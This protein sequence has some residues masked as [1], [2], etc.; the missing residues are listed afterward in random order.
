MPNISLTNYT[1]QMRDVERARQY[2]QM[3]QEQATA[4]IEQQTVNGNP[5][6][7]GW[8]SVLAKGLQGYLGGRAARKADER[9]AATKAAMLKEAVDY[10]N[11]NNLNV[12]QG[13]EGLKRIGNVQMDNPGIVD[14]LKGM[15]PQGAPQPMPQAPP[16]PMPQPPPQ[17]MPQPSP[18]PPQPISTDPTRAQGYQAATRS[19][20]GKLTP[21]PEQTVNPNAAFSGFE[22]ADKQNFAIPKELQDRT[23]SS[24][25]KQRMLLAAALSD[26]PY[27]QKIAPSMYEEE[28]AAGKAE[29]AFKLM[30]DLTDLGID[31]KMMNVF[32]ATGDTAGAANYLE[33]LGVN[34]ENQKAALEAYKIKAADTAE[35]RQL[36]RESR[37]SMAQQA[38]ADRRA[39]AAQA[40]ADRLFSANL[41]AQDRRF[42]IQNRESELTPLQQTQ[43]MSIAKTDAAVEGALSAV[44]STPKAFSVQRGAAAKGGALTESLAA[45]ADTPEERAARAQVFNVMS[46]VIKERAGT[47]Q[48]KAELQTLNSFLP[49]AYDSGKVIEDKLTGF[50]KYLQGQEGVVMSVGRHSVVSKPTNNDPMGLR[51]PQ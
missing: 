22:Y 39:M 29:K 14:R 41:A 4:P 42:A 45:R 11:P 7:I 34:K 23:R 48:S 5:V 13:G 24:E 35:Q 31:S 38:S 27:L 10:M 46:S 12:E 20:L 32:R 33:K 51:G 44:R 8:T 16:Q 18:P 6:P 49:N 19:S 21:V 9:E 43:L 2:A 30:G 25:E 40:S 36:D 17:P 3:L 26:N 28:R 15:M 50:K 1:P 37:E 47:A